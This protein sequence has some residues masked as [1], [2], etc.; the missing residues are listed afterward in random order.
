MLALA[1]MPKDRYNANQHRKPDIILV[2]GDANTVLASALAAT[3][4]HISPYSKP[5]QGFRERRQSPLCA[6]AEQNRI[7][8]GHVEAGLRSYDRNMPE[9]INKVLADHVSDYLFAPA[10]IAKEN[11]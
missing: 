8:V 2:E 5:F 9:E 10:K 1:H 4:L 7:K 6:V 11:F 3:K